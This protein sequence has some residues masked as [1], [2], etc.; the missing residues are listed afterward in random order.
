MNENYLCNDYYNDE[1]FLYIK[2]LKINK[3][4]NNN[5]YYNKKEEIIEYRKNIQIDMNK[6]IKN[7][8]FK[9]NI[10]DKDKKEL[11]RNLKCHLFFNGLN[12]IVINVNDCFWI[13]HYNLEG[14][15]IIHNDNKKKSNNKI[16]LKYEKIIIKTNEIIRYHNIVFY[17]KI[18]IVFKQNSFKIL[19]YN[20]NLNNL[21]DKNEKNKS[22]NKKNKNIKILL[23]EDIEDESKDIH[24]DTPVFLF[25]SFHKLFLICSFSEEDKAY[26]LF[27]I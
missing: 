19:S 16:L 22:K 15:E 7:V 25:H 3:C 13:Y 20:L 24:V 4:S 5:S 14:N 18:F 1:K 26:D 9:E 10:K 12:D 11:I 2:L 8:T 23:L 27:E 6:F 17:D 21:E